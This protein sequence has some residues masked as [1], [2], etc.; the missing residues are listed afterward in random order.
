MKRS[1]KVL[2]LTLLV[3]FTLVLAS[4]GGDDSGGGDQFLGSFTGDCPR[5]PLG[6][7]DCNMTWDQDCWQ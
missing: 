7:W 2:G 5:G 6:Y 3:V 1:L 4:C